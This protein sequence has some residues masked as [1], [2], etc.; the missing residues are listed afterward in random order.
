MAEDIRRGLGGGFRGRD[1]LLI[2]GSMA[3][4]LVA[5]V[6]FALAQQGQ[7]RLAR[8][9]ETTQTIP[10][11]MNQL[12]LGIG[13]VLRGRPVS[14]ALVDSVRLSLE[15]L[16]LGLLQGDVVLDIAPL[17]ASLQPEGTALR[18]VW[19]GLA[20]Q[21]NQLAQLV[22]SYDQGLL[23][24]ERLVDAVRGPEGL[25]AVYEALAQAE[26]NPERI[27]TLA[28]QLSDLES[29]AST[30]SRLFTEGRDTQRFFDELSKLIGAL[31]QRE[32]S[33]ASLP[34]SN[35]RR[36]RLRELRDRVTALEPLVAQVITLQG[37]AAD[38]PKGLSDI[39]AAAGA[40]DDELVIRAARL[41]R[42]PFISYSSAAIALLLLA[43]Y[44]VLATREVARRLREREAR[45]A[46]QQQAILGLLD[47]IT[48]LA[49][50]DLTVDVT[51]TEDFTGAIADSI[52]YTVQN[53]RSLVGTINET[54]E[55]LARSAGATQ[56]LAT[57]MNSASQQQ[58]REVVT[59]TQQINAA[60]QALQQV[61][62]KADEA[63]EQAE[64]SATIA[65]QGAETADRTMASMNQ[66]REQ[67]QD[68]SKR[69]K[70][71]GE[72]SQ[73]IGHIIELIND[74]AEQTGTLALNAAI[75]AAMAGEQGRGFAVVAEEV[76]RL[77]E[78]ASN[79]TRQVEGLVK[80]IQADTNEAIVS[81]ERSTQNVVNGTRTA[82]EAG[83]ALTQVSSASRLIAERV[84]ALAQATRQQSAVA[85]QL[86]KQM[87]SIREIALQTSQASGQTAQAV[88]EL[89]KLSDQLRGSVSGFKLPT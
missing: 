51:V 60:A 25:S 6:F 20:A 44:A 62:A 5:V 49:D 45:E 1:V 9:Q 8:W 41:S 66:L 23:A 7:S 47:E 32:Q 35:D 59:I 86:A 88:G 85:T 27:I 53:M 15:E 89:N 12:V 42:Y 87:Q 70:R 19:L 57:R 82:E 50:G 17:P 48:N 29:F 52:N 26:T 28:R 56:E 30:A 43:T 63:V 33:L 13:E 36:A 83:S 10:Q 79:A 78:R 40:V 14:L 64:Q 46:R 69:I 80:T 4:M 81:M 75:Q 73:E 72:S 58:A 2:G 61:S 38:L 39:T 22:P 77:A 11:Q 65:R 34:D 71:L 84:Q 18:E 3:L 54:S 31:E 67:I 16:T 37:V 76:Q 24:A 74:I 55:K 21:I 68:T